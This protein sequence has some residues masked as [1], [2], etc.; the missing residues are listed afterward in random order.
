M[1]FTA[2]TP[3]DLTAPGR[4][5]LVGI[6]GAGMS[7]I[8][9]ILLAMGRDVSGSDAKDSPVVERLRR[10]GIRIA[11]GHAA[12]LVDDA[13]MVAIST[14]IPADNVEVEAALRHG[15]PVVSR[16]D[17]LEAI[18][19][20]RR[21]VA[22]SGTHGKTTTTAMLTLM[23]VEAGLTPSFLIGGDVRELAASAAWSAG[24]YL[25]VEADESDGTFLRL[26]PEI[27]LVTN[28]DV[29]HVDYYGSFAALSDAFAQFLSTA[30]GAVVDVDQPAARRVAPPGAVTY[31]F[32]SDADFVISDFSQL[33]DETSFLLHHAGEELGRFLLQV[34]GRHNAANAT[35]AIA[36]AMLLGASAPACD[37]ALRRFTGVARRF[38]RRG[39]AGG[40]TF[41]DD[42]AHLPAEV[43]ATVAAAKAGPW[44][45]VVAV[46]QPHRFSRTA[47][48]GAQFADAFIDADVVI[49]TGIDPAGEPARPG[50]SAKIV[51]DAVLD[52][53]PRT[54][55]G[56]FPQRVD[57]FGYLR[58]VLRPGDC[59]LTLGAGNLTT[60]PD[61][62]IA[63]YAT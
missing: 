1:T 51:L 52:A 50:I 3:V 9:T 22:V 2:G 30:P 45:R 43:A 7:G 60:L 25:I 47:A 23:L 61:E 4:I 32:S 54:I 10:L 5:H 53:H 40:I 27:A 34:P 63:S 56:Y 38:E 33:G 44:A 42:Y 14:A 48:V 11:V 19:G 28:V 29:D 8:A 62:L 20:E 35:G 13:A 39:E 18:A 41:I 36:T 17:L 12:A 16:A 59:C 46:F 58:R 37:R 24:E 15:V 26:H 57:L 6:G 55:A 31:G 21:T 49:I